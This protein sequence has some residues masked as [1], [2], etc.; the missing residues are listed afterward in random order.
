MRARLYVRA[1]FVLKERSI[2]QNVK[3]GIL[4]FGNMRIYVKGGCHYG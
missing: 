3:G 1:F 4:K 2:C